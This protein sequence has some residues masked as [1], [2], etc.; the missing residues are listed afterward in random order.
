MPHPATGNEPLDT[1][2]V[3]SAEDGQVILDGP[4]GVA[5]TLTPQ[6]AKDTA[7]SLLRAAEEAI[8]Q[9]HG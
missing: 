7:A 2:G 1:A 3:A 9:G 6:A 4:D 5:I 8:R